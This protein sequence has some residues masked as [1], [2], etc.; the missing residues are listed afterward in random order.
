MRSKNVCREVDMS[1]A[2]DNIG[3]EKIGVFVT[4][5]GAF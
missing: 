1:T 5:S 4:E 3:D 2:G